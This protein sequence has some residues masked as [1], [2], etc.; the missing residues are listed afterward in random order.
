MEAKK[1]AY[2]PSLFLD[3]LLMLLFDYRLKLRITEK[4]RLSDGGYYICPRCKVPLDRDYQN[5]CNRCGQHL[6]WSGCR[7]AKVI[8]PDRKSES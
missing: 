6:D 1:K 3:S 4:I 7:K 2:I 8:Y 5:F